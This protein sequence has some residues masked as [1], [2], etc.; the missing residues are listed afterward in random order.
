LD[1]KTKPADG[2]N[3]TITTNQPGGLVLPRVQLVSEITLEPFIDKS[4][5]EWNIQTNQDNN[6]KWHTGMMVYNLK[7]ADGFTPGIYFWD[8]QKW[9]AAKNT[10]T[11][12]TANNG[13]N[14]TSGDVVK[15]GGQLTESTT[16]NP[17][18]FDLDF[19]GALKIKN[20]NSRIFMEGVRTH[21]PSDTENIATLGIDDDSGEVF[22]MKA[23]PGATS[24]ALNYVE[25]HITGNGDWVKNFDTKIRTSAY[26]V[27]IV[28]FRFVPKTKLIGIRVGERLEPN[29]PIAQHTN[30]P[31]SSS[32]PYKPSTHPKSPIVNV[33]ADK[34]R[35]HSDGHTDAMSTWVLHADYAEAMPDDQLD[36][37]WIFNCLVINN[38]LVKVYDTPIAY[39]LY[40]RGQGNANGS[41]GNADIME[42][43]S[44]NPSGF[45]IDPPAGLE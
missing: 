39:G 2:G 31:F 14:K 5:S 38:S 4:S 13:L 33:Y 27:L 28:G 24:K 26:T 29:K 43:I 30:S 36:G 12:V 40:P 34:N 21:V 19:S 10:A 16:V 3:V 45:K 22:V 1:L 41:G 37:T 25:Y 8:G 42:G 23:A 15:L 17:S 11:T 20:P 18:G 6:K 35:L 9:V 7:N 32:N 44:G